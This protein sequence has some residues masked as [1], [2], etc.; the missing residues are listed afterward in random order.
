M[1]A[2]TTTCSPTVRLMGKRPASMAGFIPSITTRLRP[3]SGCI[4]PPFLAPSSKRH[5]KRHRERWPAPLSQPYLLALPLGRIKALHLRDRFPR[6]S[7]RHR[8]ALSPEAGHKCICT[9]NVQ[10][11]RDASGC[12]DNPRQCPGGED[13]VCFNSGLGQTVVDVASALLWREGREGVTYYRLWH[14]VRQCQCV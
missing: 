3:A 1:S 14:K 8:S 13:S 4:R 6:N 5:A 9:Q 10:S 12:L 2:S 11:P 7:G